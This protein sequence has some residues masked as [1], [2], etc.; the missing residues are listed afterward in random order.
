[1][2]H[3][4]MKFRYVKRL[5]P[6]TGLR[7][8]DVGCGNNSPS[9]TKRWFP[10]CNYTGADI[11]HYNLGEAD[12]AA[13]DAFYLLG[14]DG[15]GY[16]AIPEASYDFV[17]LNHVIEHIVEPAP[18]LAKLCTKLKPGGY[19]WVAF[20]SL[21]SLEL[22]PSV[23]ETL[24]FCDD[25]THVYLPSVREVANVLLANGVT[26]VHAGRS[27]E[28]VLTTLGDCVKFAKR[29]L[30]KMLTGRFSGRG[31][32]YLLGFEDHVLGHRRT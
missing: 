11:Q 8:L 1:M 20:P 17:I 3:C 10:G 2:P 4:P 31:M 9:V 30:V 22:P 5:L 12:D 6:A 24:N 7:I 21:R 19:I 29:M 27:R 14:A 25:P 13:M 23:D 32:W 16:D 15:S 18:V 28:G 26:V